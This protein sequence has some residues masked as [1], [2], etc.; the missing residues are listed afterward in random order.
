[1]LEGRNGDAYVS[2][3]EARKLLPGDAL[4]ALGFASFASSANR[5]REAVEA[6][7]APLDWAQFHARSGVLGGAYF[8]NLTTM[9]HQL[10][11]HERELAEIRHGQRLHPEVP[12]LLGQATYALA[13]LGR[14]DEM[15]RAVAER[16][17]LASAAQRGHFLMFVGLEL[18]AHGH[19]E[20]A[21][22]MLARSVEA[23]RGTPAQEARGQEG[24]LAIGLKLTGRCEEARA[25]ARRLARESPDEM[26]LAGDRGVVEA[27]CGDRAEARRISDAL[28]RLKRPY[29]LGTNTFLR[30][31][32]AAQLGEKDEAVDLLRMAYAQGFASSDQNWVH[33][34]PSLE[35]LRG[36][37]PYEALMKPM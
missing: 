13:A 31:R 20:A 33:L 15:E 36:Y 3:R 14:L 18:R 23:F 8:W 7:T 2:A 1:M 32:I 9:L 6:L 21:E 11:E 22:R 4:E 26:N 24:M 30:A 17:S 10:G 28:G 27:L 37:P 16:T 29:L 35:S 19:G 34:E 25:I 12:W 5:L